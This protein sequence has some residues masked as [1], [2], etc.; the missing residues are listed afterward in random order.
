MKKKFILFAILLISAISTTSVYAQE[1]STLHKT[2]SGISI[3]NSVYEK[4]CEIYSKIILKQ[5]AKKN[6]K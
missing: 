4:L 3:E 5:L 6:T 2:Q 1:N